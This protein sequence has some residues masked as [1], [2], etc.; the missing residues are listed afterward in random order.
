M[1]TWS[2]VSLAGVSTNPLSENLKESFYSLF[3]FCGLDGRIEMSWGL[4]FVVL[5]LESKSESGGWGILFGV[6]RPIVIWLFA[7]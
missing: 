4:S 7:I 6:R 2:M 5:R 1:G 3:V